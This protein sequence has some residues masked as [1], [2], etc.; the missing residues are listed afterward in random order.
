VLFSFS[1][2]PIRIVSL[3]GASTSLGGFIYGLVVILERMSGQAGPQ[4]TASLIALVS[5]TSGLIL[6]SLGIISEYIWRIWNE[7]NNRPESIQRFK[8]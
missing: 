2:K 6:L 3:I 4:G 7:V 1:I 5:F 8:P